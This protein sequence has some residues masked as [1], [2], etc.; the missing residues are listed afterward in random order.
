MWTD[1]TKYCNLI[2]HNMNF[3]VP[4]LKIKLTN[5]CPQGLTI[6]FFSFCRSSF[7]I[8]KLESQWKWLTVTQMWSSVCHLTQRAACWPPAARTR[9][10]ASSSP[11]LAKCYRCGLCAFS[12]TGHVLEQSWMQKHSFIRMCKTLC[13]KNYF[14]TTVQK[15]GI[16]QISFFFLFYESELNTF[17]QQGYK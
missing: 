7:G 4:L 8:L 5:Y 13:N 17:T 3:K 2:V 15:F 11:A 6:E 14:Y 16:S 12:L 10:S 9:S 1:S